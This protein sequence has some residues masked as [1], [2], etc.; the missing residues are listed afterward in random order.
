M[1]IGVLFKYACFICIFVLFLVWLFQP[2]LL[3][4]IRKSVL[5]RL[6]IFVGI[7]KTPKEKSATPK[8]KLDNDVR[9]DV[10]EQ[11]L[12]KFA[13]DVN[14]AISSK[15]ESENNKVLTRIQDIESNIHNLS[16]QLEQLGSFLDSLK[17]NVHPDKVSKEKKYPKVFYVGMPYSTNPIGFW[18]SDLKENT[19]DCFFKVEQQDAQSATFDLIRSREVGT[20][21]IENMN[22]FE[23]A[24][25]I[26]SKKFGATQIHI[27]QPGCLRKQ[28]EVWVIADKIVIDLT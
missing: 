24:C 26:N 18:E 17:A 5:R 7:K 3:S 2:S 27:L 4:K 14:A 8:S 13:D 15:I 28:G 16:T 19:K 1:D 12:L 11:L 21:M 20:C 10:L 25:L 9:T 22:A 23:S 6:M